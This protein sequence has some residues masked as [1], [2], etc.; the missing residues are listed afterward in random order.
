MRLKKKK[1]RHHTM[2]QGNLARTQT[3]YLVIGHTPF[4]NI[5]PGEISPFIDEITNNVI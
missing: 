3:K 1:K 2:F 4:G 5:V